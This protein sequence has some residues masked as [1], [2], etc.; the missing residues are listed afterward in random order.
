MKLRQRHPEA[1]VGL[2][3]SREND[4]WVVVD[5]GDMLIHLFSPGARRFLFSSPIP[6]P[7]FYLSSTSCLRGW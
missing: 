6:D 7:H 3:V 4:D 5:T 1:N 2:D